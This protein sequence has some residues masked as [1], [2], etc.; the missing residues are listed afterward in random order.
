MWP[1]GWGVAWVETIAAVGARIDPPDVVDIVVS[2][3]LVC[4]TA[5]AAIRFRRTRVDFTPGV[6]SENSPL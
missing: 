1:V 2:T 4:F 5:W 6:S 3:A